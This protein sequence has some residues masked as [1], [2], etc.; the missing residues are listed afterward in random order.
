VAAATPVWIT[1][2]DMAI[3]RLRPPRRGRTALP[4]LP[5]RLAS[6]TLLCGAVLVVYLSSRLV[7]AMQTRE[8]SLFYAQDY[9]VCAARWIAADPLPLRVFNQYGEGG[10]LAYRLSGH[11]DRIFVFGDA[12]LMGDDLL[13]SYGDVESVNPRWDDILHRY[14]TDVV[15]F[16]TNAPL[17]NVMI[18]AADWVQ[19]YSDPHN[20]AFAPR[21]RVASLQLAPQPSFS[22]AGDTCTALVRTPPAQ[23]GQSAG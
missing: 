2:A 12:A 8:D 5:M 15:L 6:W 13:Y 4:P 23:L 11:G 21:D 17:T 3:A 14:G 18:H 19:V 9:P 10:Y 22:T 20:V 16:D 7:P 1:Q